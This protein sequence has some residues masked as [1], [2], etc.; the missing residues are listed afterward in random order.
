MEPD[1]DQQSFLYCPTSSDEIQAKLLRVTNTAPGPNGLEYRHL[2]AL[3]PTSKFLEIICDRVW[4]LGIPAAWK[5][6]RTVPIYKNGSSDDY[7]NFRP[8]SLIST[9]YKV[10]SGI[11]SRRICK[12]AVDMSWLSVEQK[13]FLPGANGIQ[14]HTHLLQCA[15]EEAKTNR[16]DL[17]VTWL[18]LTN[19]FGSIPQSIL[20]E[21]IQSLP[22]PQHLKHSLLD[23]YS[24]NSS[25]FAVGKQDVTI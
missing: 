3:D 4:E 5:T 11:L 18:D 23:I 22:L 19:G 20:A 9:V 7:A 6:S 14:E 8:I 10:Y 17:C 21:L 25:T 12:I 16:R 13:G 15:V 2:R 24:D 1:E